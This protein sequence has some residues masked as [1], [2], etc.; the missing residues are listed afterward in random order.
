MKNGAEKRKFIERLIIATFHFILF[1]LLVL[2]IGSTN[3]DVFT[4]PSMKNIAMYL[5]SIIAAIIFL[6]LFIASWEDLF[7]DD[8]HPYD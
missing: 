8:G 2:A 6:I 4:N 5:L 1:S 3:E 7:D